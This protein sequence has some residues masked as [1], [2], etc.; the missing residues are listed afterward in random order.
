[1]TPRNITVTSTEVAT[2]GRRFDFMGTS[3]DLQSLTTL[4][5]RFF[6]LGPRRRPAAPCR[7]SRLWDDAVLM[8][9][10]GRSCSELATLRSSVNNSWRFKLHNSSRQNLRAFRHVGGLCKGVPLVAPK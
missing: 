5:S 8:A 4:I 3:A 7:L 6:T 10:Q 1:M 9:G 2:P